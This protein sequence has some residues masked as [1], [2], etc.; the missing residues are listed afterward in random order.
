[1]II[2][3]WR[4]TN[5]KM[6]QV[7]V[8]KKIIFFWKKILISYY[9]FL[10]QIHFDFC[11]FFKAALTPPTKS[12]TYIP[13]FLKI[14]I[15]PSFL[16]SRLCY[17]W[18]YPTNTPNPVNWSWLIPPHPCFNNIYNQLYT[19]LP[20]SL[21]LYSAYTLHSAVRSFEIIYI[22]FAMYC[23]NAQHEE[24]PRLIFE[25]IRGVHWQSGGIYSRKATRRKTGNLYREIEIRLL[26]IA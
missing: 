25:R 4:D 21:P 7:V 15:S 5:D 6:I 9:Y 13:T 16:R 20:V 10:S 18:Y 2:W 17:P 19:S 22:T 1:M 26:V 14:H 3:R 24:K 12:H 8:E 11:D 23:L